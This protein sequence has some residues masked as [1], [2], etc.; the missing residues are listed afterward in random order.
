MN[1]SLSVLEQHEGRPLGL[2][3]RTFWVNYILHNK[4]GK[5]GGSKGEGGWWWLIWKL[6]LMVSVCVL[7]MYVFPLLMFCSVIILFALSLFHPHITF[8]KLSLALLHWPLHD[9]LLWLGKS[10]CFSLLWNVL[11][12][13]ILWIH[14]LFVHTIWSCSVHGITAKQHTKTL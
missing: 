10:V 3:G 7:W 14:Q 13:F 4:K 12:D 8:K 11:W 5:G 1:E 2:N 9:C 6:W